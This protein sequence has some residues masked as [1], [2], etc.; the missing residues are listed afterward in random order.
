MA[1]SIVHRISGV[2]LIGGI[3]ALAWWLFAVS[4]GP[5]AYGF[6]YQ[7]AISPAGQVLLFGFVWA[8]SYHFLNGIRHLCWDFGYGLSLKTAN[9]SGIAVAVLSLIFTL[10]VLLTAHFD[11][12]GYYD[13]P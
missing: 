1:T 11:L 13:E 10:A 12:T 2:G 8:Y 6:F 9:I 3:L 5:E 7:Q 4:T